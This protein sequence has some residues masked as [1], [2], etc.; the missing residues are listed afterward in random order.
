MFKNATFFFRIALSLA[1]VLMNSEI[2]KNL[3]REIKSSF[4]QMKIL[5][6]TLIVSVALPRHQVIV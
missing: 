4:N 6:V 1:K 2:F 5:S 3:H